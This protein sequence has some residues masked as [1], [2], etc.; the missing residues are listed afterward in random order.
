MWIKMWFSHSLSSDISKCILT[1]PPPFFFFIIH[2]FCYGYLCWEKRKKKN[3]SWSSLSSGW[4]AGFNEDWA[5]SSWLDHLRPANQS[6][7]CF[8]NIIETEVSELFELSLKNYYYMWN[9]Y[10]LILLRNNIFV[11]KKWFVI[12][13]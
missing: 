11:L 5:F 1:P 7:M 10:E 12:G 3:A 9:L 6:M 13:N 8:E 2:N 4:P